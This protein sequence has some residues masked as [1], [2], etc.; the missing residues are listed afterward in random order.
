MA[1]STALKKVYVAGPMTGLPQFNI[2]AFERMTRRLRA[3]GLEVVSPVERDSQAVQDFARA[4]KDG[5][6]SANGTIAG[7]TWGQILAR[8]VI[9][10]A[11]EVEAI[12]VL[13]G[14]NKS[15]GARLETFVALLCNKPVYQDAHYAE[16]GSGADVDGMSVALFPISKVDLVLAI[17]RSFL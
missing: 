10:V 5:K 9:I 1:M 7:E 16:A 8:D 3:Y 12:V 11:D 13:P 14:W 6:L 2:P 15:K 17:M 4:S